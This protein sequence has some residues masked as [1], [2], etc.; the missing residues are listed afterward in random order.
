MGIKEHHLNILQIIRTKGIGPVTFQ[1]IL[2]QKKDLSEVIE[3]WAFFSQKI[4]KNYSPLFPR[5]MA[6]EEAEK[7]QR[8]GGEFISYDD[9]MYPALLKGTYDPPPLLSVLGDPRNLNCP[10]VSIIGARNAS[11]AGRRLA[12]DLAWA[13]GEKGFVVTSGFA[14]GIDAAAHEG[15]LETGTIA[16]LASGIDQIYPEEN[17]A[18][19]KK[20]K[21][22]GTL[23]SEMP[24]GQE[25]LSK[26]FPRRNRIIAAISD[27]LVVIEAALRSGSLL[28][29]QLAHDFGKNVFAFPG[30]PSDPRSQGGNLLIRRGEAQ[31]ITSADEFFE[32]INIEENYKRARAQPP[33][34]KGEGTDFS[35]EE[36]CFDENADFLALLSS[37]PISIQ[38][39]IEASGLPPAKIWPKLI[40]L[41]MMGKIKIDHQ[42][43][44]S[45][46]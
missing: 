10:S 8:M 9:D 7:L 37:N 40:E 45:L 16:V 28:T 5:E 25:P 4:L 12:S 20:I 41:E 36:I 21:E 30:A 15:G 34:A 2:L 1:K 17:R 32:D 42:Q 33:S 29:V 35:A 11:L 46:A 6:Q 43:Q 24:Y 19:Y 44:V 3:D 27:H 39:I 38:Q 18:L 14:R 13:I 22:Q 23:I 31:L 26:L